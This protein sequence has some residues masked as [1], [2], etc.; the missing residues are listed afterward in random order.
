MKKIIFTISIIISALT[1]Y[2]QNNLCNTASPFCTGTVYN[3]PAGVNAGSGQPGPNYGC[4]YTTPNPAWYY[5]QVGT[6]GN[7]EI[8]MQ[9]TGPYD[10]DFAC[11]GPFTSPTAP[12]VAQLT[13]GSP[14]PSHWAPGPSPDYP[15]LNMVDCSYNP[16][17]EEWC[18]I[19]N[20]VT[21][22]YYILLITN[23][24]NQA[25]NI[26]FSQTNAGQPGAGSTNCG[27]LPPQTQ[28]NGPL[29][30]GDTL[31]LNATTIPNATYFWS[32]PNN[33]SSS[34]Q[35][36]V[37]PNATLAN[38]GQYSVVIMVGT[39]ISPED[40]TTVVIYPNP[41]VTTISD[42]ICIGETA[43]ISASG[44]TSYVWTPGG[45]SNPLNVSPTTTTT[46]QV[47]GSTTYGNKVCKGN[48]SAKVVVYPKPVI[49][50]NNASMCSYDSVNLTASGAAFYQWSNGMTDSS[51]IVKPPVSTTYTV[52]GTDINQCVDSANATVTVFP[53]PTIS[54]QDADICLGKIAKLEVIGNQNYNFIWS[55]TQVGPQLY[56]SPNTSTQ[57]WVEATDINGCKVT[58]TAWVYV[59]PLPIASFTPD[60]TTTTTNNPT[61]IFNNQSQNASSYLWNF[62]EPNSL[63][64]TSTL[65]SPSHTYGG[66][67]EF[68]IWLY[69]IS[70]YGCRD[71]T[72]RKILIE[73]PFA[74]Y[75]PNAFSPFSS[76]EENRIFRPRGVGIDVN[77]YEMRIFD[78]WGKE[79]FHTNDFEA[80]W[81][82]KSPDGKGYMPS[83][84]YVYYIKFWQMFGVEKEYSGHV[85]LY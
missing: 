76:I 45:T 64:N 20:A 47:V 74:F 56:V 27:I 26:I 28:N 15:T 69:T 78:R 41:T 17:W 83:G 71:S 5:M 53:Q 77:R 49:T 2:S 25:Q 39:Q 44:A 16:S 34:L 8:H 58:D 11:W 36:P 23:F 59:H 85:T 12:C 54:V 42:T 7:I 62:G 9:G 55:N 31:K 6:S 75:L 61:I 13:A 32:G 46:Y 65:F 81:D 70:D 79:I 1:I 50:V 33:F 21:G 68:N 14:T 37:I 19:P 82:G 3:F 73:N 57:Y 66:I 40:T 38:A 67:G 22:Q 10:I 18:Y 48:S 52:I 60:P 43:T 72:M 80:G 4:L 51:I 84:V 63:T 24:S 35:N 29:C 30:V